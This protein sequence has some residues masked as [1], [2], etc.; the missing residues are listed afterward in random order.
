MFLNVLEVMGIGA[1]YKN[2]NQLMWLEL[3]W[4]CC[5]DYIIFIKSKLTMNCKWWLI[6]L[7]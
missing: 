4:K 6:N 7:T 5:Q 1:Y 3:G 2:G